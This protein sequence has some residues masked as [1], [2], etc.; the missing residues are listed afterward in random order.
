MLITGHLLQT[1][2]QRAGRLRLVPGHLRIVDDTIVE[3]TPGEVAS[4]YDFGGPDCMICPGFI[5]THLHLP[6]FDMIGAHG[7]PL[8]R[9]L[10]THTFP[11]EIRWNDLSHAIAMTHRVIDQC[12]AHGTTMIAAYGTSNHAAVRAAIDVAKQ[13]RMA[14]VIGQVLMDRNAPDELLHPISRQIDETESLLDATRG[15]RIGTAVTPRFAVSCSAELLAAAGKLAKETGAIVQSHLAETVDECQLIG[16]LFDGATYVDV[17]QAAGLMTPRTIMGHGIHLTDADRAAVAASSTTIAH[18]PTANSF[19]RS[20]VMDRHAHWR[21]GVRV[22]LGSDIGAGYERSMVRV[23]RAMIESAA[24]LG[25]VFP[26][27][28]EA[29]WM[30][31]HGNLAAMGQPVTDRLA[32]GQPADILVI[33]P[34]VPWLN[35]PQDHDGAQGRDAADSECDALL[36]RWMFSWDDRW[37]RQT[38]AAGEVVY[39]A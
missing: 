7:L 29:W 2:P 27:A 8:L 15:Q 3:V 31:T 36:S 16:E 20:G 38:I 5:D 23:G 30:I 25:D 28:N 26:D 14:G 6:Q 9:W 18:C 35:A 32:I 22:S 4:T 13:R 1:D 10:Q 24:M 11:S 33:R 37:L 21:S 12:F 39:G 34:D 17:Y 19:L